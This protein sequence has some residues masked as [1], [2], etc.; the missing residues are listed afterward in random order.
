MKMKFNFKNLLLCGTLLAFAACSDMDVT[1][2]SGN[3]SDGSQF[4][5]AKM[6][7]QGADQTRAGSIDTWSEDHSDEWVALLNFSTPAN[8]VDCTKGGFD[9]NAKVFKVPA[10]FSGSLNFN[11]AKFADGSS[12][13]VE[14]KVDNIENVNFEGT[15]NVYVCESGSLKFGPQSGTINVY[16]A[17]N[18][19]LT[20]FENIKNVYNRGF[21]EF[22]QGSQWWT[23]DNNDVPNSMSIYSKDGVVSFSKKT[24]LKAACDIHNMA[25]VNGDLKIQ[26][27]E[28]QYVC[29]LAI[30]GDLDVTQGHLQTAYVKANEIKFDGADL[31]LLPEAH[32]VAN[33]IS[34][35]NSATSIKGYEGSH[36]LVEAK[37]FYFRNKN[38]FMDSFSHNIYFSVTGTI[39][40]EEIL[41]RDNGQQ[42]NAYSLYA[43]AGDYLASQNGQALVGRINAGDIAGS[44]ACGEPYGTKTPEPTP[45]PELVEIGN[46]EAPGHDHDA[47]KTAGNRRLSATSI[48]FANGVFYVSYHMRG[49]NY[50][51]DT[52]DKDDV[53]GCIETWTMRKDETNS[54]NIVLGQYMWTNAFDFNHLIIDGN[55]IVTVGHYGDKGA[56]IGKMA[57]T[58]ANFNANGDQ[59]SSEFRFKYLTTAEPIYGDGKNGPI[60]VDYKNAGDGNCVI[61]VGNEYYVATYEGY[62]KLDSEFNRIKDA[63]GNVAFT[64]TAGSAKYIIE[65]GDEVAVLY[66]NERPTVTA[67]AQSS[68]SIATMA[69]SAFPFSATAWTLNS[70]VQPVDG[71]NTLAWN[72]ANLLAGLGKG[73]LNIDNEVL[74]FG[75]DG[76]EPVNGIAVDDNYIYIATGS[77]LRVLDANTKAEIAKTVIPYMSANFIKVAEVNGEK[78]IAVAFGQAGI[79]VFKLKF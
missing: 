53:E 15:I 5:T 30:D 74:N 31:Y 73:G 48:D 47:D 59:Y 70:Y 72:G 67:T 3:T 54:S 41:V 62:G 79:K 29:G 32:V 69:K 64:P 13:Y 25:Y 21:L 56:I 22:D 63:A 12:I 4:N 71:K 57:N 43:N 36:A 8:A 52:Y 42:D 2:I 78:V 77:H 17:G 50:A 37:D 66:L 19:V 24:D 35:I 49:G 16:N 34:M 75:K 7:V 6:M 45:G 44:P 28:T 1:D 76:Q 51:G 23:P 46:I 27:G 39:D 38:S 11:W 65:K 33:K 55:D 14:G 18:L 26:N 60:K 20:N 61:K 58:F 68:A 9:Q 10:D 40:I